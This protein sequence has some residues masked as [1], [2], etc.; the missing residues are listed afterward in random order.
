M[1]SKNWLTD[2]RRKLAGKILGKNSLLPNPSEL[3]P[4]TPEQVAEIQ[5][6]FPLK[7]FFIFGFPRSGTTLLMRVLAVH[8]EVHCNEVGHFFTRQ[9]D[10]TQIFSS[11]EIQSWLEKRSNRWTSGKKMQALLVRCIFDFIMER[12]ARLSGKRVVGDKTP[13]ANNGE[14]VKRMH[15]LYPDAFLIYIL[16]DGRDAVLSHRFQYFIDHP[17][18][19]APADRRIR[20]DYK[21]DD[22]PFFAKKRS[23]FTPESLRK[24][25]ELWV[26]NVIE[27]DRLG[28]ELYGDQYY[29]LRY[30]D[31][32]E[33]PVDQLCRIWAFL[34]VSP[35]F[36]DMENM[37][38]MMMKQNPGA[39]DQQKKEEKIARNLPRGRQGGWKELFTQSDCDLFKSIAGQTLISLGYEKDLDW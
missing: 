21:R 22:A 5:L 6:V 38:H 28:K 39:V 7:K 8:P 25:T 34:G 23:L 24:E 14:A 32:L 16:R 13:N 36:P 37:I 30:E 17:E 9:I 19:L 1:L 26:D 33:S 29:F 27:T 10:A 31:F 12:D 15:L 4:I 11:A 20:E 18:Y 3:L 35:D 2:F